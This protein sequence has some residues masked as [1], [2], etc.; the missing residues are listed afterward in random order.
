MWY[1]EENKYYIIEV[2]GQDNKPIDGLRCYT[3]KNTYNSIVNFHNMYPKNTYITNKL[4]NSFSQKYKTK[5]L[6][7]WCAP[8]RGQIRSQTYN[9][10][11][12]RSGSVERLWINW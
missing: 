12:H 11:D 1:R 3:E 6:Q 10:T 7:Y 5:L 4:L 8:L 9:T 2:I